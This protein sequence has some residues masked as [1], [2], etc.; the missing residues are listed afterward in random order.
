M[1][2]SF[3]PD[4]VVAIIGAVF[5]VLIALITYVLKVRLD[6]K[7][8]IQ[9]LISELHRRRAIAEG[10]E[11]VIP[12]A[13]QS[14]DF[15][16]A[17]ASVASMRTEIRATRDRVRQL[18]S[19][20]APLSEMTRSCNRYLELSAAYPDH[21]AVYLGNLRRE[22]TPQV[23]QLAASRRGIVAHDPGGGAF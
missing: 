3:I 22:L 19:L 7:R 15:A 8:A 14:A 23:A 4:V 5:T 20:Q 12:G 10:P 6:E 11:P 9:S 21:Y 16:R 13:E 2:E 17:N 1:W 18:D